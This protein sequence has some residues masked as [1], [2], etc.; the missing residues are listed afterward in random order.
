MLQHCRQMDLQSVPASPATKKLTVEP[1]P[2]VPPPHSPLLPPV[3]DD[4]TPELP[5]LA[6]DVPLPPD[7]PW[8]DVGVPA[9][10][11]PPEELVV[12]S[13]TGWPQARQKASG[14]AS[15]ARRIA[16]RKVSPFIG[17]PR[18]LERM[19][20]MACSLYRG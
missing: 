3:P 20:R 12:S 11:V 15:S 13:A 1:Q 6:V 9:G 18:G 2:P 10:P 14:A 16:S 8:P 19:P 17:V 4:P 5:E 7:E